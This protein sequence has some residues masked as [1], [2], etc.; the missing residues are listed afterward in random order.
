MIDIV[1]LLEKHHCHSNYHRSIFTKA[2]VYLN[3]NM[4]LIPAISIRSTESI[5]YLFASKNYN[6]KQL[7]SDVYYSDSGFFFIS[8]VIQQACL[9]ASFYVLRVSDLIQN[10]FSPF[11]VEYKRK[12]LNDNFP[13]RR[14][15]ESSFQ[16]GYFYAQQITIFAI[17]I[18]F[19]STVPIITLAGVLFISFRHL[20]DSFN[21]LTVHRKEVESKSSIF[22]NIIFSAQIILLL[23]QCC[24]LA[25]F[26]SYSFAIESFCVVLI[27]GFTIIAV[28]VM[29]REF[30]DPEKIEVLKMAE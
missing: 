19:S 13:W 21:I 5:L 8:L 7:L 22:K 26:S 4:L 11:L 30:F 15:S 18:I 29:N 28:L 12:F 17:V 16:Y 27:L 9:S 2:M 14:K 10:W 6:P 3:I 24:M 20:V 23:Y 1:A 25:F